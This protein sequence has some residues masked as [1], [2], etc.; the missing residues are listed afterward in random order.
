MRDRAKAA[1]QPG[2]VAIASI[3]WGGNWGYAIPP[4]QE[5]FAR[6]LID[7]AGVD[8]V[9]GHSAHHA[10]AIE[11]YNGKLILYGC[12]DLINDYEGIPKSPERARL[13]PDL[14]V[15]YCAR[16]RRESGEIA[17]LHMRAVRM[18]RLRAERAGLADMAWLADMLNRESGPRGARFL[19]SGDYAHLDP[20][21]AA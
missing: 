10:K 9:H 8:V 20:L 15:I 12:G 4:Q 1:K 14:G 11:L 2:D 19:Q 6:A 3:H 7:R 5:Q 16:L 13:R 17:E 18:R 21:C